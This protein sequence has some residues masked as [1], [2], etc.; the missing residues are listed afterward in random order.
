M[1]DE[2]RE[3]QISREGSKMNNRSPMGRLHHLQRWQLS[4]SITQSSS[5]QS[6]PRIELTVH[7][8]AVVG[9]KAAGAILAGGRDRESGGSLVSPEAGEL[10]HR[11]YRQRDADQGYQSSLLNLMVKMFEIEG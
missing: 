6:C 2:V 4:P 3:G 1:R 11:N 5:R 9:T 7:V 10:E 8:L